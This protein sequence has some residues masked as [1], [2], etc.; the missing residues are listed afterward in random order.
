MCAEDGDC[1]KQWTP[2]RE[3]FGNSDLGHQW[4]PKLGYTYILRHYNNLAGYCIIKIRG[5]ED[6][7]DASNILR[8]REACLSP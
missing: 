3:Q 8:K 1:Q 7:K 6:S 5:H 2:G 4:L